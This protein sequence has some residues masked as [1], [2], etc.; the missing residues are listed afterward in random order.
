MPKTNTPTAP[1]TLKL[2]PL[3]YPLRRPSPTLPD[4]S[5]I[6]RPET[7]LPLQDQL[8]FSLTKLHTHY[9]N[10]TTATVAGA[11]ARIAA[12]LAVLVE[13]ATSF[14]EPFGP[15]SA[16]KREAERRAAR[17]RMRREK[18]FAFGKVRKP[19]RY[20]TRGQEKAR[21]PE[22]AAGGFK[23][24]RAGG[25]R[26]SSWGMVIMTREEI[27]AGRGLVQFVPYTPATIAELA[28]G[29]SR[30]MSKRKREVQVPF[31]LTMSRLPYRTPTDSALHL[32]AATNFSAPEDQWTTRAFFQVV[33]RE[34]AR[35]LEIEM[36][37]ILGVGM[38]AIRLQEVEGGFC[39]VMKG[40]IEGEGGGW[41][42]GM[43][44]LFE[45]MER[46]AIEEEDAAEW[47]IV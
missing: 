45:E 3:P 5:H 35:G 22:G 46:V 21:G 47:E 24:F 18:Y 9:A 19:F 31:T 41:L 38:L 7:N 15:L 26:R 27:A 8:Q 17:E 4:L 42:G 14:P 1:P 10:S 25:V 33:Q 34:E 39:K 36:C 20:M 29:T 40:L 11:S 13:V 43:K 44:A 6:F 37:A 2:H 30:R 12:G 16:P 32:N 28:T 23:F